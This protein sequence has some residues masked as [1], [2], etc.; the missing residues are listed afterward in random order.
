MPTS[1]RYEPKINSSHKKFIPTATEHEIGPS[2]EIY[3]GF[4]FEM[5]PVT[6]QIY[7]VMTWAMVILYVT[8]NFNFINQISLRTKKTTVNVNQ[9]QH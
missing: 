6:S 9:F 5:C 7:T 1:T 8:I 4:Q 2:Y 3:L